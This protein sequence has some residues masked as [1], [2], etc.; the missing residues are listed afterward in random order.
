[1]ESSKLVN[2]N[3]DRAAHRKINTLSFLRNRKEVYLFSKITGAIHSR[4]LA[5]SYRQQ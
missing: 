4:E 5:E 3:T 2:E 1:M